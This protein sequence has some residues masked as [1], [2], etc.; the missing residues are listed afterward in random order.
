M[1]AATTTHTALFFWHALLC[2]CFMASEN[3][4][5]GGRHLSSQTISVTLGGDT[6]IDSLGSVE[7]TETDY[8]FKSDYE[9]A[10]HRFQEFGRHL[11]VWKFHPFKQWVIDR[12]DSSYGSKWGKLKFI[13]LNLMHLLSAS[14]NIYFLGSHVWDMERDK[15]EEY[16]LTGWIV[17]ILEVIALGGVSA[18][19][20]ASTTTALVSYRRSDKNHSDDKGYDANMT[21]AGHRLN[22]TVFYYLMVCSKS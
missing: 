6:P 18:A 3:I 7:Q 2:F 12:V 5:G 10:E 22:D 4:T 21:K 1:S 8:N 20:L 9:F 17:S 14:L 11:V 15:K 19:T 16:N 13:G